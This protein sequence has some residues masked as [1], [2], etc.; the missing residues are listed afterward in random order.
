[1]NELVL[2]FC[3]NF[4]KYKKVAIFL[5]SLFFTRIFYF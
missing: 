4:F 2:C 5:S 1:M 3:V